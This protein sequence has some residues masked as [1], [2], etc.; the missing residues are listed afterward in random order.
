M[1][2]DW[3]AAKP[4]LC[5]HP[6]AG[7]RST[8]H[9]TDKDCFDL[10]SSC[11]AVAKRTMCRLDRQALER[12]RWVVFAEANHANTGDMTGIHCA[13]SIGTKT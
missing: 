9:M 7:N 10:I 8:E 6:L 5:R 11:T 12:H 2:A 3:K 13:H 4:Q 1:I